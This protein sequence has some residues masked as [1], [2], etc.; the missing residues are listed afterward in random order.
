MIVNHVSYWN[1]SVT[2]HIGMV[3]VLK[4]IALHGVA[5]LRC[6]ALIRYSREQMLYA[7]RQ[8]VAYSLTHLDLG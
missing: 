7:E 1:G 8:S 2:C 5:V 3:T 6:D 4:L